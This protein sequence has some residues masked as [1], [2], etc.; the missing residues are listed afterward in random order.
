MRV[1]AASKKVALSPFPMTLIEVAREE[2]PCATADL[3]PSAP[4]HEDEDGM[5]TL[6]I[7]MIVGIAAI[8]LIFTLAFWDK[9]KGWVKKKKWGVIESNQESEQY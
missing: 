7:V 5:E 2:Q 9:I 3:P 8:I 4:F 6:Q 1:L